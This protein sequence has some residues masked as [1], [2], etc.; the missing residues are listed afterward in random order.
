MNVMIKREAVVIELSEIFK[1]LGDTTRLRILNLLSK[2]EL[3][4]YQIIQVLKLKEPNVSKHLNRMRYCGLISC[5]KISQWCYYSIDNDFVAQ[6][7]RLYEFLLCQWG[8]NEQYIDDLKRL[9]SFLLH[10]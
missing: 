4:V 3:C 6:N 7:I 1:V 10:S 2:Q 9:D 5:N 8:N